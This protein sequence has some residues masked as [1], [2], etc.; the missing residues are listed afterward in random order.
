MSL[1][2]FG[3]GVLEVRGEPR[4]RTWCDKLKFQAT[5]LFG[6]KAAEKSVNYKPVFRH[7]I[8]VFNVSKQNYHELKTIH[9]ST[10]HP[11]FFKSA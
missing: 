5:P 7:R 10:E 3:V 4:L 2:D 9:N 11:A 1:C 6:Q 8:N